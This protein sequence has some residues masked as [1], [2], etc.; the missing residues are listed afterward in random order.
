MI[1]HSVNMF[2]N[3]LLFR[4][5]INPSINKDYSIILFKIYITYIRTRKK[6]NESEKKNQIL[7]LI[8]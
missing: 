6:L 2:R 3:C 5:I 7:E 8:K 1:A 4:N